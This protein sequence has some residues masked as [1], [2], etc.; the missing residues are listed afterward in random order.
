MATIGR[1]NVAANADIADFT[2]HMNA[3]A[4]I[5]RDFGRSATVAQSGVNRLNAASGLKFGAGLAL[6]AGA[7]TA[8]VSALQ[9]AAAAT[10]G[11]I[12]SAIKAGSDL[13][14][15]ITKT[16]AVLGSA[17]G[18]VKAFADEMASKFGLV[19]SEVLDAASAFGGL[20]KG[21][22]GLKGGALAQFSTQFTKLAADLS[23]F[24]NM[25]F[26]ETQRALLVGLSGEQ[27]DL[28]KRLGVTLLE[29][30]VKAYA[31]SH[32]IAKAGE[33]LN[34]T[35]KVA[36]RTGLIFKA[37]GDANGDLE[38]TMA[39]VANASRGLSGRIENLKADLG[40]AL[41]TITQSVLGGLSTAVSA[42]GDQFGK[43]QDAI[44]AWAKEAVSS[45]GVII[46]VIGGIGVA[47]AT[48]VD[49]FDRLSLAWKVFAANGP[50]PAALAGALDFILDPTKTS[51][52]AEKTLQFF[53][54]IKNGAI[55][56]GK[57]LAVSGGAG[58]AAVDVAAEALS[59][60]DQKAKEFTTDL[61][62]QA[63]TFGLSARQ[64]KVYEL[65]QQGATDAQVKQALALTMQL[66]AMDEQKKKFEELKAAAKS[67][68]ESTLTPVEKL[69]GEI[70]KLQEQFKAG[71]IDRESLVRGIQQA[72]DASNLFRRRNVAALE[73]G[74][75]ASYSARLASFN[76]IADAREG[77]GRAEQMADRI[78]RGAGNTDEAAKVTAR[79]T[80]IQLD[81]LKQILDALKSKAGGPNAPVPAPVP[82]G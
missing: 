6:G 35:Q 36:A 71:L 58:K 63:T 52:N 69:G 1:I 33:T 39:G 17:S 46:S 7:L 2:A 54:N 8:A 70:M 60:A 10:V 16:D 14:E 31:F 56:A 80:Q 38:R 75:A 81:Y 4:A 24:A 25:D 13:N 68:F 23:S 12:G 74:S 48:V 65:A 34:N 9:S 18:Q 47:A 44:K 21:L 79:N 26:R 40:L 67:T 19:K 59:K 43:N 11:L 5:M 15:V 78:A 32:G 42:I 20:G 27:S 82:V 37:L 41:S 77:R 30:E 51:K 61:Q 66:D 49:T 45:G 64:V 57:A 53:E 50:T 62:T 29:D 28:L 22:G 55:D 3:A 73:T 72:Q 76:E